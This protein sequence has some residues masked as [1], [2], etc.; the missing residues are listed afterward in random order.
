MPA[1]LMQ[2]LVLHS[3]SNYVIERCKDGDYFRN[4]KRKEKFSAHENDFTSKK[5]PF[6]HIFP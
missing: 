4:G 6:P 5:R 3:L 2:A 1:P